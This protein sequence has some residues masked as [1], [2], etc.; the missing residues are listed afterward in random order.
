MTNRT[1]TQADTDNS[2]RL[3]AI[4]QSKKD[5]L[6]LTQTAAAEQM[7]YRAQS[8]VSMQLK[9]EVSLNADAILKWAQLLKVNPGDIDPALNSLNFTTSQLRRVKVAVI[10]RMSGEQPSAFETVEIMTQMNRQVYGIS[11]D[12]NGF[13]PFAKRGSTL[14]VSQEEEP[15]SGDEVFIRL[16][17][18]KQSLHMIKHYITTDVSRGV[19]VVRELNGGEPEELALDDVELIDP[20]VS[21]D[22][23]A[24]KRPIRLRPKHV[25]GM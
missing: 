18:A 4:W 9:G 14:I 23:P 19:I 12:T 24:V 6:G 20:I 8:M 25:N 13:E 10:A 7:G 5:D 2:R 1:I 15:V 21:V 11:V 3:N 17:P 22:R 16:S